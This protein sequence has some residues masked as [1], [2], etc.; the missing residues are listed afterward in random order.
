MKPVTHTWVIPNFA[1][2]TGEMLTEDIF[3][4]ENAPYSEF[5]LLL[6][7]KLS[8]TSVFE[9]G[10]RNHV[11]I[12]LRRSYGES[13]KLSFL[14]RIAIINAK[15]EYCLAQGLSTFWQR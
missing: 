2:R 7:S 14:Y 1:D 8:F 15:G 12:M 4:S 9:E 13:E 11:C 6:I 5:D 3:Y 10:K